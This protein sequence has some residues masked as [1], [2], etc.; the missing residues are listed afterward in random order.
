MFAH[1]LGIRVE[2]VERAHQ[3]FVGAGIQG[4]VIQ[5]RLLQGAQA[6]VHPAIDV[7]HFRMLLDQRDGGQ[8]AAALQ[9]VLVQLIRYD[10][11]GGDQRHAAAEKLLEQAAENHGIGDVGDKELVEADHPGLAGEPVGDQ[12]EGVLFPVQAAQLLV[13]PLHETVKM[14]A[15]LALKRQAVEERIHQIGFTA[16]YPAPE[17]EPPDRLRALVALERRQ[18]FRQRAGARRTSPFGLDQPGIQILQPLHG[19]FLGGIAG[20]ILPLQVSLV[21]LSGCHH[22]IG[23]T[24]TN[25]GHFTGILRAWQRGGR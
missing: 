24:R 9:A 11:G 19:R 3:A 23:L 18:Q 22:W 14:R 5:L 10:V 12:R 1:V 17:I 7:D 4:I 25:G 6:I 20:K 21:T 13:H 2:T 16:A 8:E 15:H